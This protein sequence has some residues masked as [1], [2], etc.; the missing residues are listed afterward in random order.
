MNHASAFG[1][2]DGVRAQLFY[3]SYSLDTH[4]QD[5]DQLDLDALLHDDYTRFLP[6]T[7][8]DGNRMY[9]SFTHLTG[10]S[11]NY[12]TYLFDKVIALDFFNQ[13]DPANL[14]DGERPCAIGEPCSNPVAPNPAPKLF[15]I[16]SGGRRALTPFSSGSMANQN[17]QRY[18]FARQVA[19][20]RT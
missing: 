17:Q 3:C 6:Y 20:R 9:A 14:L 10:Y 12:Y 2:A 16:F 11:S 18:R 13:F 5:P 4:N 15:R 19:G 8:I 7:W 1:R